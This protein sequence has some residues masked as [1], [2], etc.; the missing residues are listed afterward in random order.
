M[1]GR[2]KVQVILHGDTDM[3]LQQASY[4][5]VYNHECWY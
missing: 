5:D 3:P 1:L 2:I 4:D